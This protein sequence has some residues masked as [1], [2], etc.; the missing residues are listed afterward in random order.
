MTLLP[1]RSVTHIHGPEEISWG[2]EELVVLCLVRDGRPYMKS[3]IEHYFSLG[4]KHIVFLD[5]GSTDGTVQV[6]SDY[7]GVTVVQTTLPYKK[8]RHEMKQYL[9]ERFAMQDR[10]VLLVDI[11]ELFDY[12]RSGVIGLAEFLGRL[13]NRGYTAVVAQMLDMFPEKPLSPDLAV[14]KDMPLKQVHRFYDI[15]NVLMVDYGRHPWVLDNEVSNP[16]IMAMRGGI[17][18]TLFDANVTLTKH[19]LM[20]MDGKIR[21]IEDSAH[22]TNGA[23]IADISCVL[24]HYKFME[25]FYEQTHRAVRE[26]SYANG[27]AEYKKY[28]RVLEHT[29]TLRLKR[30]TATELQ[31]TD[32]LIASGFIVV[33]ED[34]ELWANA[35]EDA[36]VSDLARNDPQRLAEAFLRLRMETQKGA[37]VTRRLNR[38]VYDRG[39][40][41]AELKSRLMQRTESLQRLRKELALVQ[42]SRIWKI[43]HRVGLAKNRALKR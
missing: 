18:K 24:Y 22:W 23:R 29:P 37:R 40:K 20:F 16:E 30:E 43:I 32:E 26:E 36:L 8:Y 19:P 33:S 14:Q 12:P 4:V 3:F 41:I 10:W 11:D 38:E 34:Y 17:R 7:D 6:A 25:N 27:S 9:L 35:K 2:P 21:P 28:L 13:N 5:N 31:S 1:D 39:L 15:S 42:S